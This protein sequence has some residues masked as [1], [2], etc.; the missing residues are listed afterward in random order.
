[1]QQDMRDLCGHARAA[2][3]N[4]TVRSVHLGVDDAR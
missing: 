2:E 3:L 4:L 1:M